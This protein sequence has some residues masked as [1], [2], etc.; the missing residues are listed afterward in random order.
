MPE[1]EKKTKNDGHSRSFFGQ[2][3]VFIP[4]C[5]SQSERFM[6]RVYCIDLQTNYVILNFDV[7]VITFSASMKLNAIPEIDNLNF[8]YVK[9]AEREKTLI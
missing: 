4:I 6:Y 1:R 3:M 9:R 8:R 5:D 2:T 7:R